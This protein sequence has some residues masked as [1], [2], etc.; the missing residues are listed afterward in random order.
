MHTIITIC[1][2]TV[3]T[4]Y[5]LTYLLAAHVLMLYL[6]T[7]LLWITKVISIH[8]LGSVQNFHGNPSKSC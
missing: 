6:G 4:I 5:L 2:H 8:P 7:A 3:I 1:M